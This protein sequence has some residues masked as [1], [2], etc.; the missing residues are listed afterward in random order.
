MTSPVRADALMNLLFPLWQLV[1]GA[2]VLI[3]VIVVALRLAHRGRSRMRTAMLVTGAGILGLAV[4]GILQ[5][6]AQQQGR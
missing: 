4:I 1:I 2:V 6:A 3:A 5:A